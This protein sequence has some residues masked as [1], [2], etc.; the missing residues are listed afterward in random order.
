ME[1]QNQG[2]S[3]EACDNESDSVT[4]VMALSQEIAN[5]KETMK[6]FLKRSLPENESSSPSEEIDPKRR[7]MDTENYDDFDNLSR[8]SMSISEEGEVNEAEEVEE[9]EY[10]A[11]KELESF[12]GAQQVKGTKIDERLA[13][14]VDAGLSKGS[15]CTEK[16]KEVCERYPTPANTKNIVVPKT[17]NEI[18]K[19]LTKGQ[20]LRDVRLQKTQNLITK[21]ISAS[22]SLL[23]SVRKAKKSGSKVDL[24]CVEDTLTD[25]VRLTSACYSDMNNSRKEENPP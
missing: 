23:D 3:S 7:K 25:I 13:N 19:L 16:I 17:N 4:T 5:L 15:P 8:V 20:R 22:V 18:W 2:T 24:K 11:L 12:Y 6:A 9:D 14:I 1:E 21:S 10:D